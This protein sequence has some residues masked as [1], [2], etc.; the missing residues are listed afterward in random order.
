MTP[1]AVGQEVHRLAAD[2]KTVSDLP[3]IDKIEVHIY[4]AQLHKPLKMGDHESNLAHIA[5]TVGH[6]DC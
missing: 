4:R 6:L 3:F 2:T 5:R 1:R